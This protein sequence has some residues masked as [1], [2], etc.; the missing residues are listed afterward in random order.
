MRPLVNK[1]GLRMRAAALVLGMVLV[2]SAPALAVEVRE[3]DWAASVQSLAEPWERNSRAFYNGQVRVA[4]IDTGGEPVCCSMHLL[5][6]APDKTSEMGDRMCRL[7]SNA[8]KMGFES[9]DFARLSTRYD[10]GRGLLVTFPYR[11]YVDG[12]SHRNGVARV[13]VN[14]ERGT[15]S[16]E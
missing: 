9:I 12:I 15:I 10:A 4:L 8:N 14:L 2:A 6:L 7:V 3:C 13:R 1:R 11:L 16:P 5:I